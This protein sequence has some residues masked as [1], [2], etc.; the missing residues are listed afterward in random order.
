V[1]QDLNPEIA[2]FAN[3]MLHFFSLWNVPQAINQI[4]QTYE[5]NESLEAWNYRSH[6]LL[7]ELTD[8]VRKYA[9]S[10]GVWTQTTDVEGEVNGLLTYDR[11]I[12]RTDE[13]QWKADIQGLYDAAATRGGADPEMLME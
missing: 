2:Y 1:S 3:E 6:L 12:L 7:S 9:C 11:R 13:D 10:G 4:N 5:L 8:Q